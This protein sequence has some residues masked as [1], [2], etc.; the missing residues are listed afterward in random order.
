MSVKIDTVSISTG[1][2]ASRHQHHTLLTTVL[3]MALTLVTLTPLLNTP[4]GVD[5][6]VLIQG[7]AAQL[8]MGNITD[9]DV[10]IIERIG[11]QR[12][13]VRKNL[14]VKGDLLTSS[15]R[16]VEGTLSGHLDPVSFVPDNLADAGG[17]TDRVVSFSLSTPFAS[18]TEYTFSSTGGTIV[19]WSVTKDDGISAVAELYMNGI[20]FDPTT[21]SF[22]LWR[23]P[24]SFQA[25]CD[26]QLLLTASGLSTQ[27]RYTLYG[28]ITT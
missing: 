7:D 22:K 18:Q 9:P 26:T 25:C 15:H 4:I 27:Y 16:N 1:A 13:M 6:R 21:G 2:G 17:F 19:R 5:A 14:K 20:E 10:F 24:N 3:A 28:E 11:E 12:V 8:V 23:Q